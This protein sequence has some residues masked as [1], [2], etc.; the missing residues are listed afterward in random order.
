METKVSN[1]NLDQ[2]LGKILF[3]N[4]PSPYPREL[5]GTIVY[6]PNSGKY[7]EEDDPNVYYAVASGLGD[8]NEFA[9]YCNPNF[10]SLKEGDRVLINQKSETEAFVSYVAQDPIEYRKDYLSLVGL[11]D[12]E[13]LYS[14]LNV[15]DTSSTILGAI[16]KLPFSEYYKIHPMDYTYLCGHKFIVSGFDEDGYICLLSEEDTKPVIS[17]D[18][19]SNLTGCRIG[20]DHILIPE[21]V[22]DWQ[23]IDKDTPLYSRFWCKLN[24]SVIEGS[25]LLLKVGKGR[26]G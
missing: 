11:Y 12:G 18:G 16:N 19:K 2:R 23:Y 24:R 26:H 14:V 1:Y 25:S 20:Q 13:D 22:H 7:A 17:K 3:K 4:K 5:W 15:R 6:T 10:K 21:G 9:V 8:A